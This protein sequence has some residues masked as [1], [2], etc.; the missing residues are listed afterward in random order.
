MEDAKLCR[1]ERHDGCGA[2]RDV[3]SRA[4]H[5]VDYAAHERRVETV[6]KPDEGNN[7]ADVTNHNSFAVC[8]CIEQM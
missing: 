2:E 6:L 5:A 8:A 7:S 3:F 1:H 4:K